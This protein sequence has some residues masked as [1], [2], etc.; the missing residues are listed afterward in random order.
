MDIIKRILIPTDFSIGAGQ[1]LRHAVILADRIGAEL[2]ILHV[3]TEARPALEG[4]CSPLEEEDYCDRMYE[5]ATLYHHSILNPACQGDLPLRCAVRTHSDAARAILDYAGDQQVDLIVMAP[6][7]RQKG[8]CLIVGNTAKKVVRLAPCDVLTSGIRGLYRPDVF[9]RILVPVDFS[10]QSAR[11]LERAKMMARQAQ[12]HLTVLHVVET[13]VFP[14]ERPGTVM[15]EARKSADVYEKLE[16]FY[17]NTPG[18]DVPHLFSV[19]RGR[20]V[21]R[22]ATYAERNHIH[23]IVQGSR[24]RSGIEYAMLG[25]VSEGIARLAPCPVLTVKSPASSLL[26]ETAAKP[27]K[28]KKPFYTLDMPVRNVKTEVVT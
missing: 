15:L 9:G 5:E 26:S 20:P 16:R 22:I 6:Y 3:I 19:M 21:D 13:T 2:H 7:G 24:G 27:V 12:A 23:L 17:K 14:G 28:R 8:E 4:S 1:A 11:A 25:S 10:R 18:P